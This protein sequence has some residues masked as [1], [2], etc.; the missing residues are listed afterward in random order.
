[1]EE[2]RHDEEAH[3]FVVEIRGQEAY[4]A[5][6]QQGNVLDFYHTLVPE[7]L[8][9]Q[10]LAE[11][12]VKAGFDYAKEKGFKVLPTCAYVSGTFLKRN[13]QYRPLLTS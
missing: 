3:R 4:L 7:T 11:K 10:G 5:Y 8:R 13:E 12:V 6:T 1:M 9:G 2:V